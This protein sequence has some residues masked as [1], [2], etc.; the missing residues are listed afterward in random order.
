L[1]LDNFATSLDASQLKKNV[2]YFVGF[3]EHLESIAA[4]TRQDLKHC[5]PSPAREHLKAIQ[6][7]TL[8]L[9]KEDMMT[10]AANKEAVAKYTE[11]MQKAYASMLG[12]EKA[13]DTSTFAGSR[14]E[15]LASISITG[16]AFPLFAH[17]H[18]RPAQD[19]IMD[20]VEAYCRQKPDWVNT[21]L[22]IPT[23]PAPTIREQHSRIKTL[24]RTLLG[25]MEIRRSGPDGET[26]VHLLLAI[27][28]HNRTAFEE[29]RPWLLDDTRNSE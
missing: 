23:N 29:T 13:M 20:V 27:R 9:G 2:P 18:L 22:T 17:S 15:P 3:Q 7:A 21:P 25:L 1:S 28:R 11:G 14:L 26:A 10:F 24:Y 5:R 8:A 16:S 4:T 19:H 12:G 6:R